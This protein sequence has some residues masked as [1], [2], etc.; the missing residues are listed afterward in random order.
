[1]SPLDIDIGNG[2]VPKFVRDQVLPNLPRQS[3]EGIHRALFNLARVLTPW[4]SVAQREAIL[5]AYAGQCDRHVPE[6]EIAAALRDG[7]RYAWKPNGN[8][9][10]SSPR[11]Q[12]DLE[13]FKKFVAN[14]PRVDARWLAD[15][16]PIDTSDQNPATFLQALYRPG[17]KVV[18][19]D[20][21]RGQGQAVWTHP[22][23]DCD[24]HALDHFIVG[25]RLGVWFLCNPV[26]GQ[27]HV[28]DAGK[29]S[30]RSAQNVVAWRYLVV[31]S[32][33]YDITSSEWLTA[34]AL[35]PAPIVSI[36]ETG[37]RLAHALIR[38][39]AGSKGEWDR[40]R[41]SLRPALARIGADMGSLSAVRLTRLPCCYRGGRQEEVYHEFSEGPHFQ[42]PLY[43]NP[44]P[45]DTPIAL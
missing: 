41:D 20:D 23:A 37:G 43:I 22:G 45:G 3:G 15:R 19:F 7:A 35:L 16:S 14:A 34:L 29:L 11:P 18:I 40:A 13:V 42:R 9:Y 8:H 36:V 32:D 6:S 17:E 33:R 2:Y 25:H 27:F 4:R 28:N 24:V 5:R 10:E 26:D 31:E 1:M 38:V 21:I 12:F 39:D 30:R 44:H